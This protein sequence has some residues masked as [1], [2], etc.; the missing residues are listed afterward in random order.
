MQ[1]PD[2]SLL[3]VM[4]IFWATYFIFQ[5]FVFTPLGRILEERDR[6]V[7]LSAAALDR[8]LEDERAAQ[9]NAE[10]RLTE[11][12]RE[13]M[14]LR[15]ARRQ[16]V[17]S[18]RQ[19]MTDEAREAARRRLEELDKKLSAEIAAARKDLGDNAAA[20]AAEITAT[21]TKRRAA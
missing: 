12:R 8:A 16:M 2:L 20:L 4:A 6:D 17:S 11:A 21:V 3:L 10:A 13:A 14:A 19:A 18:R 1:L 15:D 9:S 7:A 5:K